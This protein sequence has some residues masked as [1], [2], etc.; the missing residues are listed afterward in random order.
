[1]QHDLKRLGIAI[2]TG[3]TI[4]L[5]MEGC[6]WLRYALTGK[7]RNEEEAQRWRALQAFLVV[8]GFF[9]ATACRTKRA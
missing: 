1:M 7:P 6:E 3:G 2:R 4:A 8:V 9:L 5:A